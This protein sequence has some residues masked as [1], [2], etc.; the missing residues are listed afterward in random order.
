MSALP[1]LMLLSLASLNALNTSA[2]VAAFAPPSSHVKRHGQLQ[3]LQLQKHVNGVPSLSRATIATVLSAS[4]DND[5][6]NDDTKS[7][8]AKQENILKKAYHLYTSYFDR[9]WSDTDVNHRN[10][11]ARER[12]IEAVVRVRNMV[13]GD[14]GGGVG[15]EYLWR[16]ESE[17]GNS[18]SSSTT[19]AS[20]EE[21]LFVDIDENV[22]VKVGEACDLLL[23]QLEMQEKQTA[24]KKKKLTVMGAEEIA[25]PVKMQ[26]VQSADTI[27]RNTVSEE[28]INGSEVAV[29]SVVA[30][31]TASAE[32]TTNNNEELT[33]TPPKKK[34]GSRSILFG[35]TMGLTVAGWVYSGNYIFTLL[36]TLMTALGQ[37]EYYRMVMKAGIYPARRIS[38]VGACAM[39]VTALFAPDLH[40][41]V[42]PVVST[43]AMVWF[44]TMRR[45]ITSISEIATTL[46]GIFYLGY[47]P[48]FWV[49]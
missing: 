10:K 1:L 27:G 3:Q 18:T 43:W 17:G 5:V 42:L 24:K 47:I 39:F 38:V 23:D 26:S 21:I 28:A 8:K 32:Q 4:T 36:F 6:K 44:L 7:N 33:T 20:E 13:G 15:N 19:T 35:A 48:S 49:R 16:R 31:S 12:A 2:N 41:I 25:T 29:Q 34:K 14:D 45:T 37:L 46:T 11:L 30:Q 9:L 40:Q 22:R